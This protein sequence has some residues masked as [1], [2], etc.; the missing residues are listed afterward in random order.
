MTEIRSP[1]VPD[2][3][4]EF[5]D[6]E[7]RTAKLGQTPFMGEFRREFSFAPVPH[8]SRQRDGFTKQVQAALGAP[9]FLFTGWV[10]VELTLY[11]DQQTRFETPDQADL[12]NYAKAICDAL[13]GS[14][15]I[16]FDDSQIQTLTVTW[17][18]TYDTPRFECE[19]RALNEDAFTSKPAVLYEMPDGLFYPLGPLSRGADSAVEKE[20]LRIFLRHIHDMVKA[21][22]EFRHHLRENGHGRLK[23][24]QYSK[25]LGPAFEG[26]HKSRV[27]D[28]GFVLRPMREWTVE[29]PV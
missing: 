12:D 2:E 5:L 26:F 17:M 4:L 10:A 18:D 13:K 3:F 6:E 20:G 1:R 24:F 9:Q 7:R 25:Y 8:G 22:V 14:D 28:G 23:A 27:A 29:V 11:L 21:R 19:I 16:M 15:G